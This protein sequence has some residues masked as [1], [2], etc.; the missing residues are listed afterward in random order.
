MGYFDEYDL[1][2]RF[3]STFYSWNPV[4]HHYHV[5]A[6]WDQ[7][8]VISVCT[9]EKKDEE[10]I[11]EALYELID[12]VPTDVVSI[13]V[14][15]NFELLSSSTGPDG[16]S[17]MIPFYP[18]R[19]AFPEHL[20][21]IRRSQLTEIDRLGVQADHTTYEPAPGETRHVVFKYYTNEGNVAMFWHEINCTLRIPQHPNIVPFDR[22][23]VE[24]AGPGCPDQV[25]GFTTVFIPGGT[26]QE[27]V[28]RVFKLKY[29]RQLLTVRHF[30]HLARENQT[31]C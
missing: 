11:F 4:S 10:F 14:S 23:V 29:L 24:S 2:S 9:A 27:N 17:A 25:V 31:H 28:S 26:I 8:R 20:P 16:D 7:R 22:L 19:T 15:D 5:V 6:D 1:D 13:T 18:E 21:Q 3:K 30:T 12:D